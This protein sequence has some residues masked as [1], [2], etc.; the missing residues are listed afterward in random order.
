MAN[1]DKMV[2]QY[3]SLDDPQCMECKHRDK[4]NPAVCTAFPKGIP[5]AILTNEVDH[6]KPYK[7][8]HG[9]QFEAKK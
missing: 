4:K 7:G 2:T 8:D 5:L 6:K 1:N 9:I 3:G